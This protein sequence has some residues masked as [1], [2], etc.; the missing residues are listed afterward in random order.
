L[1]VGVDVVRKGVLGGF[2]DVLKD[3][4]AALL[5]TIHKFEL[6]HLVQLFQS[7]SSTAQKLVVSH[8]RKVV[9]PDL[10]SAGVIVFA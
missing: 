10:Y 2:L 4:S 9:K 1:E 8:V 5:T 3:Y 7:K 6:F